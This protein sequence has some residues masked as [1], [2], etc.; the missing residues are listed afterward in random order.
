MCKIVVEY[1]ILNVDEACLWVGMSL[2]LYLFFSRIVSLQSIPRSYVLSTKLHTDSQG[3]LHPVL[4][5]GETG[6]VS[7]AHQHIRGETSH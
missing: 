1:L 6:L 4:E 2:T 5:S 3:T 7:Q